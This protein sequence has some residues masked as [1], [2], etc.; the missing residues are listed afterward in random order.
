MIRM[1]IQKGKIYYANKKEQVHFCGTYLLSLAKGSPE[2]LLVSGLIPDN[3]T[4]LKEETMTKALNVYKRL[5]IGDLRTRLKVRP[6]TVLKNLVDG[7]FFI[8]GTGRDE[9]E[10]IR[11]IL[12]QVSL[13]PI[14]VPGTEYEELPNLMP[15][16][17]HALKNPRTLSAIETK[18]MDHIYEKSAL[19]QKS[20]PR[21]IHGKQSHKA[22]YVTIDSLAATFADEKISRD[23]I[24]L[25]VERLYK[26][27]C[28]YFF[29][30][31]PFELYK[32]YEPKNAITIYRIGEN[33][34]LIKR[35]EDI[36]EK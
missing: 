21:V 19:V 4:F 14:V 20:E 7:H 32:D 9:K 34:G 26:K 16:Y 23:E 31:E 10:A 2:E 36:N 33:L 27:H 5:I 18:I 6:K 12:D 22:F 15:E 1:Y 35:K 17:F 11:N 25:A 8:C 30:K 3:Y 29:D 24:Y 13:W 28:I